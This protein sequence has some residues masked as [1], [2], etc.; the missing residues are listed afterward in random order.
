M[1]YWAKESQFLTPYRKN[2]YTARLKKWGFKKYRMG[3][4]KWKHVNREIQKRA[5]EEQ[6]LEVWVDG[7]FWPQQT[8]KF[9][10]HR[11]GFQREIEK[12]LRGKPAHKL[13]MLGII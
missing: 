6:N 5:A 3:A 2:Q 12:H 11:Q 4:L 1:V 9:E 10:I 8:V 7:I 13:S